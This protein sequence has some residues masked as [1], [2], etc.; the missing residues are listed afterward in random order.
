[1]C[2]QDVAFMSVWAGFC[3]MFLEICVRGWSLGI[4][5]MSL[6]LLF[7]VDKGTHCVE[8]NSSSSK[9]LLTTL[10][11][12][13]ANGTVT[14]LMVTLVAVTRCVHY[15]TVLS[16]QSRL[17]G[18]VCCCSKCPLTSH[19]TQHPWVWLVPDGTS[20]PEN[21]SVPRS[22]NPHVSFLEFSCHFRIATTWMKLERLSF[23]RLADG[24]R[25]FT[26]C[27]CVCDR[28]LVPL[29]SSLLVRCSVA[30]DHRWP[31]W[32]I[33]VRLRVSGFGWVNLTQ[34]CELFV[35]LLWFVYMSQLF[36][37]LRSAITVP[38]ETLWGNVTYFPSLLLPLVGRH[39]NVIML[40]V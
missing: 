22:A 28:F 1:M 11:F 3:T 31:H 29:Y 36:H 40:H 18:C 2:L 14:W 5:D 13:A 20:H 4:C 37:W 34:M 33:S 35:L 30:V 17:T 16:T 21:A 26:C 39:C 25:Y 9:S 7:W 27:K 15:R 23:P 19:R 6:K 12:Y 10:E 24:S 32:V 8:K 38:E